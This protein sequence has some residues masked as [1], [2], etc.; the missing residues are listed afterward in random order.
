MTG[1]ELRRALHEGR[2]VYGTAITAAAPLFPK[3]LRPLGLDVVFIDTEHIPIDRS[4]L[5]WM[6][7]SYQAMGLAPIVR[8]P[9]ADFAL[10]CQA[11]DAGACSVI[12]PYLETPAE[13][14]ML[15]GAVKY[16]P[17]KGKRLEAVLHGREKLEPDLAAYIARINADRALIVNIESRP[18]IEALDDILDVPD[19]DGVL[20]GPHDLSCNVGVPEQF[21]HPKFIDAAT[22][23]LHKAREKNV[24][25]GIHFSGGLMLDAF[26]LREGLNLIIFSSDVAALDLYLGA[27]IRQFREQA[28][29]APSE[30]GENAQPVVV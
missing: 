29:D 21:G 5:A 16:R 24:G 17:L 28:G 20:I 30:P 25:A 19:L 22:R 1:S 7:Q 11:V 9:G 23:I 3:A 27:S 12:S 13:A 4:Q 26:W 18:A 6:C 15:R 2:R 10:A 14:M 8:V